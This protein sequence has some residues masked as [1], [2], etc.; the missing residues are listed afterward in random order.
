M[1]S[2]YVP[3]IE[4]LELGLNSLQTRRIERIECVQLVLHIVA[5]TVCVRIDAL[6]RLYTG[7]FIRPGR[8]PGGV[9]FNNPDGG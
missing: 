8:Q 1:Y 9:D 2:G 4:R 7:L 6:D 5:H 3:G